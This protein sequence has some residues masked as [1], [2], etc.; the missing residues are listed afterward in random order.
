MP[1]VK[2]GTSTYTM[3]DLND[4]YR[5]FNSPAFE[6]L[7]DGT[8][9][10]TADAVGI[11]LLKVESSISR[12]ADG[13]KFVINNAFDPVKRDFQW[14]SNY[15]VLGKTIEVKTG[16]VDQFESVFYGI[17]TS[18]RANF[19]TDEFP[20]LIVSAMDLSFKMMNGTKSAIF[21]KMKFSDI[22]KKIA[23][24]YGLSATVD[25]TGEQKQ[26]V[27][28]NMQSDFHFLE[29]LAGI[30]NF[31]FFI[32]GKTLYFRKPLTQTTPV[33]T[34]EWGQSLRSFS[35]EANLSKQVTKV[36][37]FGWDSKQQQ[38][39]KGTSSQVNKLGS[40][41]KTGKDW[42]SS[43]G[44]FDLQLV[45]NVDSVGEANKKAEAI[46][47]QRAMTLISGYGESIGLPVLQAG[48]YIKLAHLGKK[49]DQPYYLQTV[50]HTI[51]RDG[52]ITQFQ[53]QG[54]AF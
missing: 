53:V 5:D 30:V 18:V 13:L 36:T 11:T 17:I 9:I 44:T 52:Y 34:L 4:K 16:Y 19:Q 7:I 49:F 23:S 26:V 40:N 39:I 38:V 29:Q 1:I 2:L 25:D 21:E 46:L 12:E 37:V 43:I 14:L 45:D 10:V 3:Q 48:R 27:T 24:E 51:S 47:N 35:V 33:I 50:T 6:I 42:M 54:N 32:V 22:V 15:F 41:S 20:E 8:N 31:D 28:Q